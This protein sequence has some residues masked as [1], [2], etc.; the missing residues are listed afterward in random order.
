MP[1]IE[2]HLVSTSNKARYP[3]ETGNCQAIKRARKFTTRRVLIGHHVP[4]PAGEY[5]FY[6]GTTGKRPFR[7]QSIGDKIIE[8]L[9]A[10]VSEPNRRC[11]SAGTAL[12]IVLMDAVIIIVT[13]I[14]KRIF[15]QPC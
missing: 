15:A 6:S 2:Q 10:F 5:G 13:I 4:F 9:Y 3:T 11:A 7:R 14:Q 12:I 8:P 1:H